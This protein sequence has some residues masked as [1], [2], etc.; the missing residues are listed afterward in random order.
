MKG[1]ARVTARFPIASLVAGSLLLGG[2]HSSSVAGDVDAGSSPADAAADPWG[3][4]DQPG[5]VPSTSPVAITFKIFDAINAITTAGPNGGSDFD[6]LSFVPLPGILLQ[7]CD[8]SSPSCQ[9]AA[10]PSAT[11]D[12]AGE[13]TLT[14]PGDFS[15][16]FELTGTTYFPTNVYL[17]QLLADASTFAPPAGMLETTQGVLIASSLD[18]PLELDASAGVGLTFFQ[19]YDCFDRHGLGVEFTLS[20]D[21]GPSTVQ[22]Y[23]Q[24]NFPSRAATE[25]DSLGTGGA[26]NVPAGPMTV[27]ATLSG[28]KRTIGSAK[29]VVLAGGAT[30]A[31]LRVRAH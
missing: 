2:C 27:T 25:T 8:P 30:F 19:V 14:V 6:V 28:T 13:A 4:L 22:F 20:A 10:A 5:E 17:G 26:I 3:C 11:T 23:L 12:D 16:F 29:V 7:A 21:A 9:A 15:G 24:D 18:V 31:W 1:I